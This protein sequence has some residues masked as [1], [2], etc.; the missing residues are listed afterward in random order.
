MPAEV[1]PADT[2]RALLKQSEPPSAFIDTERR[3]PTDTETCPCTSVA[4]GVRQCQE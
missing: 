3:T 2:F 4:F 1:T